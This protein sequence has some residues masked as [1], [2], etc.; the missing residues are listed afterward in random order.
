MEEAMIPVE[1]E[2]VPLSESEV[3][4]S[5]DYHSTGTPAVKRWRS[6]RSTIDSICD[7]LNRMLAEAAEEPFTDEE[8][9]L[10]RRETE[11]RLKALG[12][13]LFQEILKEEGDNLRQRAAGPDHEGYVVFKIDRSMGYVP[14][15]VMHDGR[16]FLSRDLAVGR[17]II[18]EEAA[19]LSPG[20]DRPPHRVV[21]TGDPT[22]DP[23]IRGD[24]EEELDAIRR[25][26]QGRGDFS[27]KVA[28]GRD[29]DRRFLLSNLP[30]TSIFHFTGHGSASELQGLSGIRLAGDRLLTGDALRGLRDPPRV[31]FLNMCTAASKAAWKGS[32][33]IVETLLRRG[34]RA[35]VASLWDLKSRSA[36]FMASRFYAYVLK[37]EPF[38]QALRK[39]RCDTSETMGG[40]DPTW[41]AY[42]LYG[43]PSFSLLSTAALATRSG[44]LVRSLAAV[45]GILLFLAI[46]L[47]PISMH[48][49]NRGTP[50]PVGVG[51]LL[52]ESTPGDASMMIDGET[53]GRTPVTLETPLGRHHVVLEKEGYKLWEAWVDVKE[54]GRTSIHATLV[55]IR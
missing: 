55:E 26:F 32:L 3:T 50:G 1:I 46:A 4:V 5:I 2:I 23:R 8:A 48:K 18:T 25:V 15:E 11:E 24:I 20:L 53:C 16:G 10:K 22:D 52:V 31:A 40:H 43:N 51:Y 54:A 45:F 47:F 30:G 28:L 36:T 13:A 14:L 39:A 34:T 29:V 42:A 12:L 21:I 6:D 44:R 49:E 37:G 7:D 17:I 9:S 38:G 35:C 33:G 27:V 19:S 41:A